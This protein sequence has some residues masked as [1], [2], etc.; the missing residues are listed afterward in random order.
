MESC[1]E[2]V[3][4]IVG[5]LIEKSCKEFVRRIVRSLTEWRAV[6]SLLVEL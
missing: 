2:F 6:R 1:K 4:R 3:R 5:S